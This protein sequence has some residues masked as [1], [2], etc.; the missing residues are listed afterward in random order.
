MKQQLQKY[1][2]RNKKFTYA[3]LDGAAV[4]NLPMKLYETGASHICL[5]RGELSPDLV[6][7]APYLIQLAPETE[8]TNWLLTEC[9][10][11]HWGIFAQSDTS[12][13]T[14]RRHFRGMLTVYDETG[15]P[16]LF[17]FYDPRVFLTFIQTCNAAELEL[18]F[19]AVNY[20]FAESNDAKIL[21]RYNFKKTELQ[22][23]TLEMSQETK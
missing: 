17:R 20:Y 19:G 18:F 21:Q 2:F 12:L 5:Y 13:T 9:W 14:M 6:H 22:K 8:F 16:L 15:K 1:L 3:V 7:V 23:T 4:P 11:K 10:G